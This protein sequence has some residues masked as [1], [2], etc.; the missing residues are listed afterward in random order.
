MFTHMPSCGLLTPKA[1]SGVDEMERRFFEADKAEI[2]SSLFPSS[3][4]RPQE[5]LKHCVPMW[6]AFIKLTKEGF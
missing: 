4:Q 1:V 2:L 3:L 6:E 5:G